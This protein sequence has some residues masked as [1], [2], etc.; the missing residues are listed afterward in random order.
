MIRPGVRSFS[1]QWPDWLTSKS[2]QADILISSSNDI[3]FNLSIEEYLF[4]NLEIKNPLL[5][6]YQND[7]TI[8]IGKHQN[9]W[10]ECHVQRLEDDGVTLARRKS[11]GGCVYQ[12]LGNSVF[13]FMN[14]IHDF[15][16]QDYKTL[17][18]EV[19]IS[20]LKSFN[21]DVEASGRNDLVLSGCKRKISGSAYKLKLGKKDGTGRRSLHH[22]TML[23][24]VDLQALQ[25]YLNPNKK[26]LESKGVDS[27]VSRVANL[28]ELCP[29]INHG[30]F[31][32]S[33]EHQFRQKWAGYE[34]NR[35]VLDPTKL[36]QIP[37][38]Q[39]I[40]QGYSE[41]SWRFGETPEFT[42]SVE[43][44]FSWAL[45]EV[46]FEVKKGVIVSGRVFTDCLN[47]YFVDSLNQCL[48]QG[49]Y[50]YDEAGIQRWCHDTLELM[51]AEAD[52]AVRDEMVPE[53]SG[54]LCQ[55][56]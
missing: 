55:A 18:N 53:L 38:L 22:G 33:L 21:V 32:D 35:V 50:T 44:K 31:C 7:K 46:Q 19:L 54:W 14:P 1:A 8:I 25:K 30:S 23:L 3:N 40:Y 12:D 16:K 9:P 39:Q 11:G 42:N 28:Q 52:G 5:F 17:N 13:S 45:V 48:E 20:S 6:L 37:T 26:K 34:F 43:H 27:V 47:P 56:I 2:G 49:K 10:K 36:E 4:E 51:G 29:S 24:N 41:W 15:S